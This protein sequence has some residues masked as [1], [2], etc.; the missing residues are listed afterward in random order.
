MTHSSTPRQALI[1]GASSGIGAATALAFAAAGIN[2]VLVARSLEKLHQVGEKAAQQGVK[3]ATY[4]LDLSD[5]S[6]IQDSLKDIL[7]EVGG[8]DILVNNAGLA[9][10]APLADMPLGDW[11][12]LLN[13]NVTNAWLCSQG[14][15]P[16]MRSR[17]CGTIINIV[18][19]AGRQVFPNWGAYCVTKFALMGLTK[20]LA[21]E[22]RS[23]GIRVIALCPGA[24]DTP[25]W[26][27][28]TIEGSFDRSAMLS[29]DSI[30]Q[31]ILYA[32][33]LPQNAL[34]E[35]LILMPLGGAL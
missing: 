14:V 5:P 28:E 35:E 16:G 10:N 29:A 27:Q 30:A 24:V 7:A 17:G 34:V 18:S 20:A 15:I 23:H 33:N 22:E 19:I 3:V 25:L 26:D 6:S 11:Q 4:S 21:S 8:I 2:L 32:V 13:L 12:Y 9:V 1:T 31:S